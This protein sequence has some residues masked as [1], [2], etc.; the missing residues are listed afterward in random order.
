MEQLRAATAPIHQRLESELDLLNPRMNLDDYRNLLARFRAFYG[1]WEER[2]AA[3]LNSESMLQ[4][5]RRRKAPLIDA[6]LRHLNAPERCMG[7]CPLIPEFRNRAQALG[8]MYVIEGSTLG[9]RLLSRHFENTLGLTRDSGC[10]FF[11][12]YG[13][14]VGSMWKS[15]RTV[16]IAAADESNQNDF[17]A[18]ATSTFSAIFEWLCAERSR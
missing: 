7:P 6:D 9:G 16:L 17:V 10:A 3:Y 14:N 11:S 15:F 2:A 1:P 5:E 12:S 13:E 18:G 8:S 4:F